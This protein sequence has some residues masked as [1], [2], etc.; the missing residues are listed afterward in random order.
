MC[1]CA[2]ARPLQDDSGSFRVRLRLPVGYFYIQGGFNGGTP[3]A[4]PSPEG[5]GWGGTQL[6]AGHLT[7]AHPAAISIISAKG[8]LQRKTFNDGLSQ[9]EQ[10]KKKNTMK[11][12]YNMI[13]LN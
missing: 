1:Q 2:P 13:I 10:I 6:V 8:C 3:L 5:R 11:G 4:P 12:N 9:E 7:L